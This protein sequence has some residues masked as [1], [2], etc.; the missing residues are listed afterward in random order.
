MSI[1]NGKVNF[2][3]CI[4][5]Q[6]L[7]DRLKEVPPGG[8]ISYE[9]LAEAVS[10]PVEQMRAPNR[11]YRF[12]LSA[13]YIAR[14]DNN[15]VFRPVINEG[16]RRLTD[17]EIANKIPDEFRRTVRRKANRS[18]KEMVVANYDALT[19]EEKIKHSVG[20]SIIGAI[21]QATAPTKIKKI[22]KACAQ[23]LQQ[24]SLQQTLDLFRD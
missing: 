13:R 11:G 24:L 5:T 1:L 4:D 17:A 7:V 2:A 18:G 15:Q 16:L 22:E 10:Y 21:A 14:R 23:T 9:E 6:L 20:L 8:T 19:N 3:I 12:L